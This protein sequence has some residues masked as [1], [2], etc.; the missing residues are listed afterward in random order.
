MYM[1]L[2]NVKGT[3]DLLPADK[4]VRDSLIAKLKAIFEKY[5]YN[6]I[7][8]PALELQDTLASKYAGGAEILK[9]VFTLKDNADRDL[10]LRYDLTVPFARV[11]ATNQE[12]KRPFK[13]Y[14]IDRVW[15]NGPIKLGRYREFYQCDVDVAGISSV[16]AEAELW[17]MMEDF[18]STLGVPIVIKV[19]NRKILSSIMNYAGIPVAKESDAMLSLDKLAKIGVAMVK[20]EMSDKGIT[21]DQA[22]KL[23]SICAPERSE[24]NNS[25]SSLN[26]KNRS[27]AV[28]ISLSDLKKKLPDCAGIK[29]LEEAFSYATSFGVTSV[30]FDVS[31]A[32]G[33][34]YYTG[35]IW[36]AFFVDNKITSSIGGG[37]RY[38]NMVG[39]FLDNRESIPAVGTSFGLDVI[40]DGLKL[41]G[42]VDLRESVVSVYIIP[43]KTLS[44]SVKIVQ[45][46]RS[47]G[48][49]ADIDMNGKGPSKNFEYVNRYKIPFAIVIGEDEIKSGKLTLKNMQTGTQELLTVQQ[50]ISKLN[51]K[52]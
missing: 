15:R 4:L 49:N 48:I 5:G 11:I 10:G 13:R 21:S 12:L 42:K 31:L 45:E 33:L 46:L 27:T 14:Q 35:T 40:I 38:D 9:E 17:R 28:S 41:A 24:K 23:L 50:I 19:N 6:P 16:A 51:A 3:R 30:Q 1:E 36:E 22:D 37:G 44:A 29:E 52:S 20:K 32:R 7:E 39:S 2:R 26:P 34:S 43:I 8:T 47:A 25:S 18:F